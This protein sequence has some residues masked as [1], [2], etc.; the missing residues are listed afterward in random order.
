M[1]ALSLVPASLRILAC[2]EDSHSSFAPLVEEAGFQIIAGPKENV[3][4]RFCITI[5]RFSITRLIRATGDNPFVFTDAAAAVNAEAMAL[6]ADYSGYGGIPTGAGV[7]SV[8]ARAL[9]RAGAEAASPYEQEHVC[10][11]LY[12]HPELFKLH[13]P[14]APLR[15]QDAGLPVRLTVDTGEDYDRARELYAALKDD[16]QRYFGHIIIKRYAEIFK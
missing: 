8:S 5:R 13:R 11:Y 14:L 7:E 2:P 15:W 6:N 1:E 12:N 9:L 3:L 4:E 10:P 16:P